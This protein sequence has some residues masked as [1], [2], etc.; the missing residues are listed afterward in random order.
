MDPTSMKDIINKMSA[1][2][3]QVGWTFTYKEFTSG[4]YNTEEEMEKAIAAFMGGEDPKV[5]W[6][7]ID[8]YGFDGI[9]ETDYTY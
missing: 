7:G 5:S 4:R 9:N 2:L 8:V 1:E 6:D 3:E